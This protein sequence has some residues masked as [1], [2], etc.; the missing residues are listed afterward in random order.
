MLSQS[1][2]GVRDRKRLKAQRLCRAWHSNKI[3]G[4]PP[5]NANGYQFAKRHQAKS[6]VIT[7]TI[8]SHG[9]GDPVCQER[10]SKKTAAPRPCPSLHCKSLTALSNEPD[11]RCLYKSSQSLDPTSSAA[12]TTPLVSSP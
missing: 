1:C 6:H 3:R 4:P 9:V 8:P 5:H 7:P 11:T 10:K 12:T 2:A